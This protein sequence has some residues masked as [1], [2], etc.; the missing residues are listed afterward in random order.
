MRKISILKL[1]LNDDV[2]ATIIMVE[3]THQERF[4]ITE[5]NKIHT[6]NK[7]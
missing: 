3:L 6:I 1:T 4:W 5:A 7:F 2:S